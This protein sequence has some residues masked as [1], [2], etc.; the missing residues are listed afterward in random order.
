MNKNFRKMLRQAIN[1]A[2]IRPRQLCAL[3]RQL[4]AMISSGLTLSMSLQIL[5]EQCQ[6]DYRLRR[7]YLVLRDLQ[8][9]IETGTPLSECMAQHPNSFSR[10]YVGVIMAGEV[11]GQMDRLLLRLADQMERARKLRAKIITGMI[12]PTAVLLVAGAV[13]T[14][15][16][17]VVVPKFIE[18]FQDMLAGEPMPK[19]TQLVVTISQFMLA[20]LGLIFGTLLAVAVFLKLA[21]M[22]QP[23]RYFRDWLLLNLPPLD[24]LVIRIQVARFCTTLGSLLHAGVPAL[25]ALRIV[26]DTTGNEVMRRTISRVTETVLEGEGFSEPLRETRVFPILVVRWIEVGEKSGNLPEMLERIAD[27]YESEVTE[28]LEALLSLI[29]P[30]ALVGLSLVAGTIVFALFMPLLKIFEILAN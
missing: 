1:P 27:Q 13:L 24:G 29:E 5:V 10:Y 9:G 25:D 8:A 20:H 4:S 22:T 6:E 14:V 16:L 12:Y 19:I 17:T 7:E 15:L 23:G 2:Q 3:T 11:S 28:T 21:S 18:V 26:Y 30:V